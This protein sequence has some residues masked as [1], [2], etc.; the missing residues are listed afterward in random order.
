MEQEEH[1][2]SP[3]RRFTFEKYMLCMGILGQLLFF[4]QAHKIFTLRSAQDVSLPG[5]VI[6]FLS[7]ASWVVYGLQIKNKVLVISNAVACIGAFLVIL[8]ICLYK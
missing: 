2:L 5:F 1:I 8:G 3:V 7:V 4:F 6:S